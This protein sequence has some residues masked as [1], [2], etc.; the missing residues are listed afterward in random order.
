MTD[1][2]A[3]Q[4]IKPQLNSNQLDAFSTAISTECS[5][6]NICPNSQKGL[7]EEKETGVWGVNQRRRVLHRKSPGHT[8]GM[9]H[10]EHCVSILRALA[11]FESKGL[12][13]SHGCSDLVFHVEYM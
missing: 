10:V 1:F 8:R 4:D 7:P 5:T 9:F 13:C 6:W 12:L 11:A 3:I 2:G